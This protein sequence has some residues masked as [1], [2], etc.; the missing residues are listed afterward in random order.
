[1][2]RPCLLVIED[3]PAD[4]QLLRLLLQENGFDCEMVVLRDGL[5]AL[6]WVCLHDSRP[7]VP[8]PDL[9]VLD[10]NL[11]KHDGMQIIEAIRQTRGL[12]ALPILVLSSSPS[13]RDGARLT[14]F[15]NIAY[16]TK[17]STLEDY[18]EIISVIRGMTL[19]DG[20]GRAPGT[21]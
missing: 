12:E 3:N 20:T 13:S 7:H 10:L 21:R 6:A 5:E 1:M 9:A 19:T 4:V 2:T 15:L 16:R 11:P 18:G 17:P 8:R 14:A